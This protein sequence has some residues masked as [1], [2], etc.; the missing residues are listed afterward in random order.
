MTE[1][2]PKSVPLS[3]GSFARI[4]QA[5]PAFTIDG[6]IIGTRWDDDG[7]LKL[8]IVETNGTGWREV[9]RPEKY[10]NDFMGGFLLDLPQTAFGAS[11]DWDTPLQ[12]EA[13]YS[14]IMKDLSGNTWLYTH[15]GLIEDG[16]VTFVDGW[17]ILGY[18]DREGNHYLIAQ[19]HVDNTGKFEASNLSTGDNNFVRAKD[20]YWY[21]NGGVGKMDYLPF[22]IN[23]SGIGLSFFENQNNDHIGTEAFLHNG[24]YLLN[25]EGFIKVTKKQTGIEQTSVALNIP[26]VTRKTAVIS[27]D[28]YLYWVE[29]NVGVKR[30]KLESGASVETIYSSSNVIADTNTNAPRDY[31]TVSGGDT[32]VFYMSSVG[33]KVYTYSLDLKNPKYSSPK[34]LA[35]NDIEI[36]AVV[37]LKF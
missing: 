32:L 18:N 23:E 19:L 21:D 22:Y 8:Y 9:K 27:K 10:N 33:S 4:D 2:S 24:V 36:K 1:A 20:Q 11:V 31:L 29:G 25:T 30:L 35:E 15:Y 14:L 13:P 16:D 5:R 26:R 12:N 7:G 3:N 34:I 28:G 37:E 17:P 6:R